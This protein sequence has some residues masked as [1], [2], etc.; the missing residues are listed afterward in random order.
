M[1]RQTEIEEDE[2]R[3]L[4]AM[5]NPR[6]LAILRA[7]V[8]AEVSAGALVKA[9]RLSQSAASQHL[10]RLREAGIVATRRDK[11]VI[12]YS[13]VSERARAI[14]NLLNQ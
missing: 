10:T 9:A 13:L 3:L 12:Y 8:D 7:L 1:F 6:R 5:A 2:D 11:Q 4:A 14:I